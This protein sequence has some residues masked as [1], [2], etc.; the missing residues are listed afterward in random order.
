MARSFEFE[1]WI[2][3]DG[4]HTHR[5]VARDGPVVERNWSGLFGEW[6][7]RGPTPFTEYAV[8]NNNC[9]E[10]ALYLGLIWRLTSDLAVYGVPRYDRDQAMRAAGAPF[11]LI[12]WEY[13]VE[14]EVG[15]SL[16]EVRG[17]V[18][19]RS[20]VRVS[21]PP[22]PWEAEHAGDAGFFALPVFSVF[23]DVLQGLFAD[24]SAELNVYALTPQHQKVVKLVDA[25]QGTQTPRLA[26][27]LRDGE[28][29]IDLSV[30]V[31]AEYKDLIVIRSLGDVSDRLD[32]LVREYESAIAA[33]EAHVDEISSVDEFN[34]RIG[35]LLNLDVVSAV[36]W[37][38]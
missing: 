34:A 17:Y 25:L 18:P 6:P 12:R 19:A 1:H 3:E 22:S 8:N 33:Y 24:A 15:E 16:G 27:L 32:P 11:A 30:G 20:A 5:Y 14:N 29:L 26:A 4:V 13:E 28:M 21:P 31:D 9:E 38:K 36:R 10:V 35:N 23:R 37:A 7:E 2:D